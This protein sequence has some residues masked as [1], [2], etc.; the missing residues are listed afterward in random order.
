M[1]ILSIAVRQQATEV[2][3]LQKL[4]E[5]RSEAND[6]LFVVSSGLRNVEIGAGRKTRKKSNLLFT[7][8]SHFLSS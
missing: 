2:R 5:E 8:V 4:Q 6:R 1:A 7:E 3:P